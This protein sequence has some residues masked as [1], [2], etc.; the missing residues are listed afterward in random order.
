MCSMGKN[1]IVY[2]VCAYRKG[3]LY[4]YAEKV[5]YIVLNRFQINRMKDLVHEIDPS[6]YITITEVADVFKKNHD[7]E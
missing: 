1:G 2:Y 6:A 4:Q 5:I 3:F 7:T